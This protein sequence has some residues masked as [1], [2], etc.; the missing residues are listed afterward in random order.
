MKK[1]LITGAGGY[2]GSILS[3]NLKNLDVF[4]LDKQQNSFVKNNLQ[5]M[6]LNSKNLKKEI[7]KFNP[8][9]VIHLAGQS[10]IDFVKEKNKYYKNNVLATKNLIQILK[11]CKSLD[12]IIFS[13][14]ASVY[15]PQKNNLNEN[16]K[17][18]LGNN[19][20]ITKFKSEN[21][22][23]NFSIKYK[24]KIIIFRFFN[25]CGADIKN[26]LGE[27]HNPETHLIPIVV[28]KIY[29]KKEIII[30]GNKHKTSDGSCIRDYIHVIDIVNAIKKSIN[31]K[32][33]R[34]LNIFNLGTGKGFSVI[35]IIQAASKLL[36]NKPRIKVSKE[37]FGDVA[38]LVCSSKKIYKSLKWKPKNSNILKIINDE[39]TW[40]K[41]LKIKKIKKKYIY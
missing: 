26:K 29:N 22:L 30:Y 10:T 16:S 39:I 19:Y 23:K 41:Y 33:K 12:K 38:K 34:N 18:F 13:S 40:Q 9:I 37:R 28:N 14:T 5:I 32:F 35:Q 31:Y 15:S 21:L 6:N 8:N 1:I 3:K 24:K 25:V 7:I 2:I 36:K 20:A 17:I 4:N 11:Q 27:L